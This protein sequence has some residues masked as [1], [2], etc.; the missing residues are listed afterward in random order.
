MTGK[1]D[2]LNASLN[3][4]DTIRDH[5]RVSTGGIGYHDKLVGDAVMPD[6]LNE[7]CDIVYWERL[8]AQLIALTGDQ[9]YADEIER[10]TYNTL[11]GSFN[12]EGNWGLRRM[13]LNEPHYV[14]PLYCYMH[15]HRCC[16][17]NIPGGLLQLGEVALMPAINIDDLFVNLY[18]PG[19]YTAKLSMTVL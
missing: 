5:E 4:Y 15:H 12:I 16:V 17:A 13:G 2:Y 10:L 1:Q 14:A 6:E 18:I 9:K 19:S 3:I 8:S 7:P 11:L